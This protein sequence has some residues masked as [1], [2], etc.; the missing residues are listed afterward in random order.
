MIEL[1]TAVLPRGRAHEFAADWDIGK[2]CRWIAT[3]HYLVLRAASNQCALGIR[4]IFL[5]QSDDG[6]H[7]A[8]VLAFLAEI[9][10]AGKSF[11][12]YCI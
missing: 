4:K 1:Y 8:L 9:V 2:G 12:T 11:R 5:Q 10:V 6:I 7:V 3:W